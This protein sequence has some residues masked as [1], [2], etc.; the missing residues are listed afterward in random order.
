MV[1]SRTE[2]SVTGITLEVSFQHSVPA[3]RIGKKVAVDTRCMVQKMAGRNAARIA[4]AFQP[5][6]RQALGEGSIERNFA[7]FIKNSHH[8]R[9]RGVSIS[10]DSSMDIKYGR[11]L[12]PKKTRGMDLQNYKFLGV[13]LCTEI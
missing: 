5:E 10:T 7:L 8:S 1:A 13:V 2:G 11:M 3:A 6:I 9:S 12:S 4:A